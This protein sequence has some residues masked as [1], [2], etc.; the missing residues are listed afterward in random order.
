MCAR[1]EDMKRGVLVISIKVSDDIID[2][3][4]Y[5][6]QIVNEGI[7]WF[8]MRHL[9]HIAGYPSGEPPFVTVV[10]PIFDYTQLSYCVSLYNEYTGT[11]AKMEE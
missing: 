4:D 11:T 6:K 2:R 1:T 3:K 7:R 8:F 9:F 10:K 5:I